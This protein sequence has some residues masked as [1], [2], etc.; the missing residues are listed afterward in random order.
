MRAPSAQ[1]FTAIEN[2]RHAM[3]QSDI[4]PDFPVFPWIHAALHPKIRS[5]IERW[6]VEKKLNAQDHVLGASDRV[7]QLVLVKSGLTAR[8]VGSPF[9]QSR[10]SV[11]ISIPG[12]LACGNLNFFTRRPCVGRYFA[13]VPSV[14]V[15]VSQD[16]VM[17]LA[18]KDPEFMLILCKQFEL[19]N[20]SDRMGFASETLLD[21]DERILVFFMSWA[22]VYGHQ[23]TIDNT[24]WVEMPLTL[25]GD[26]LR[27][28]IN[29]S[30]AAIE[31]SLASL[32][33]SNTLVVENDMMRVQLKALERAHQW[34]RS[35]EEP[36][37]MTRP[38]LFSRLCI[39]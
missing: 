3:W 25:R 16:L 29:C 31:R 28:V 11:A 20:L 15:S 24:E 21:I 5:I 39:D 36:G 33:K 32:R 14:I 4:G 23:V 6:G 35:S 2:T 26:A 13:L 8:C 22:A 27:Y 1:W 34:L 12:R 37:A 30:S 7:N 18:K 17:S 10:L 19:A 9:S 38:E